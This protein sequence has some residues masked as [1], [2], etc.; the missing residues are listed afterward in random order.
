M[1]VAQFVAAPEFTMNKPHIQTAIP[2]RRY[3]YG[4]FSAIVLGDIQSDDPV[5]YHYILAVVEEGKS[6]PH[7]F[8]TSERNR[9]NEADQG[10]H[11]MRVLMPGDTQVIGASDRWS[12]LDLFADDAL[13]G[14]A[15][16][17]NLADEQVV[18][19]L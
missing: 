18:R 14:V 5:D 13:Q 19:L 16:L 2:K 4:A 12:E 7:I 11:T 10:S 9:A 8:I 17:L 1:I 6:D 3:K 15:Q